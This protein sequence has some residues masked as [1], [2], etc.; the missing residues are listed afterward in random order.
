MIL[1]IKLE[2]NLKTTPPN[3]DCWIFDNIERINYRPRALKRALKVERSNSH[4]IVITNPLKKSS[5]EYLKIITHFLN[6]DRKPIILYLQNCICYLCNDEG[7]TFDKLT[8]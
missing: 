2:E 5:E 1:K 6:P 7:K 4:N 8:C 3:Y